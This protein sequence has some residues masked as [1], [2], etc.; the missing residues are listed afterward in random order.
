MEY[1]SAPKLIAYS[2]NGVPSTTH[3]LLY[4]KYKHIVLIIKFIAY[5]KLSFLS[6]KL[7]CIAL[8]KKSHHME[9]NIGFSVGVIQ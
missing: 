1:E 8:N 5:L 7:S 3:H 6:H 9:L 4:S 2:L